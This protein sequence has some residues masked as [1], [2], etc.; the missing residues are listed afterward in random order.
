VTGPTG[1]TG[2]TGYTGPTGPL[3]TGPTGPTGPTGITGPTGPSGVT[4]PTGPTGPTGRT[5][6]TGPSGVTGPTGPTGPTGYTGPTGP[7]GGL[8]KFPAAVNLQ[9]NMYFNPS[10]ITPTPPTGA[11]NPWVAIGKTTASYTPGS[12]TYNTLDISGTLNVSK[13]S[14]LNNVSETVSVF[15]SST[16]GSITLD[17]SNGSIFFLGATAVTSNIS[18]TITGLPSNADNTHIYIITV[19]YVPNSSSSYY[20]NSVTIGSTTYST[21][22]P[23]YIYFGSSPSSLTLSG[24]SGLVTQQIGFYYASSSASY[25]FSNITA[26]VNT[27]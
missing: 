15:P 26:F 14:F 11:N 25:V 5:G 22:G 3:G 12:T 18:V 4:G 24:T 2:P 10:T 13:Y 21:S 9:S 7:A 19:M 17:C 23:S 6:P 1:P 16:G 8:W 20:V 27:S